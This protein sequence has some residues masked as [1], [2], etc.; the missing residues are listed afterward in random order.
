MINER[1]FCR[2]KLKSASWL[3]PQ[4]RTSKTKSKRRTQRSKCSKKWWKVQIF[5]RNQRSLTSKDFKRRLLDLRKVVLARTTL[6]VEVETLIVR[7]QGNLESM[8]A[9]VPTISTKVKMTSYKRE[10]RCSSKLAAT[11]TTCN[12]RSLWVDVFIPQNSSKHCQ[13]WLK[14]VSKNGRRP[15]NLIAS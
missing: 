4:W 1:N 13:R 14:L 8:W 7:I 12:N 10:T 3:K 11:T 6:V 9:R 5:K 2:L 15:S